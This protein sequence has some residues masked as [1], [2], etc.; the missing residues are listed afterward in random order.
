[1]G[2]IAGP[3]LGSLALTDNDATSAVV[4]TAEGAQWYEQMRRDERRLRR[5]QRLRA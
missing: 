5:C 4:T 2:D 1:M 3:R